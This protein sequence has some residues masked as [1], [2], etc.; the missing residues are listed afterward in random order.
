MRLM[1]VMAGLAAPWIF[2]CATSLADAPASHAT[3]TAP[4]PIAS[5]APAAARLVGDFSSGSW[6]EWQNLTFWPWSPKVGYQREQ[7]PDGQPV[8]K[9]VSDDAG[10]MLVRVARFDLLQTPIVRWRWRITAPIAG[11]DERIKTG[12]DCAARLYFAWNLKKK[13]DVFGAEAIAYIWG[14]TRRVGDIGASAYSNQVGL[15]TLRSGPLG[16]GVWQEETRNLLADY[17]AY[18][19]RD[20][21]GP[22]SAIALMTDTDQ[23]NRRAVSWYS[24]IYAYPA[25][26]AH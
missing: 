8:I 17:R 20:P 12:D 11:A 1:F 4:S 14:N 10:S 25:L 9:A 24:Q 7:G 6:D 21:P 18:F 22:V 3:P 23:T 19:R 5:G 2:G 26:P 13:A 15:V 16:A